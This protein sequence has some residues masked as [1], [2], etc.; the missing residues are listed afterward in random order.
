MPVR[1]ALRA[2]RD[3]PPYPRPVIDGLTLTLLAVGLALFVLGDVMWFARHMRD[4]PMSIR[5]TGSLI[6][7]GVII[8]GIGMLRIVFGG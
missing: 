4:R 5:V 2:G 3:A 6:G 1:A 8:I 7:G